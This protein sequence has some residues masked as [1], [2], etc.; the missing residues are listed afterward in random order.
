M[1][2]IKN[3]LIFDENNM[4]SASNRNGKTFDVWMSA[5]VDIG[6]S[7]I[8]GISRNSKLKNSFN[9]NTIPST[10]E[11]QNKRQG[12]KRQKSKGLN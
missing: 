9:I 4:Q 6:A 10:K 8:P 5:V 12:K 11:S 2:I 1:G 3:S 7:C